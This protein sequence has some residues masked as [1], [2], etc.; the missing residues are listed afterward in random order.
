MPMKPQKTSYTSN[1][2][3]VPADFL[4]R[5]PPP[6]APPVTLRKID[7]SATPLPENGPRYA[8][9]ID[10]VLTADEC[11][12][13]VRMAEDSAKDRGDAGD[14]PW[15]PAMVNIGPGW[16]VL[17]PHYRNSDRIIWDQ[18][19][20]VD[21]LWARCRLAPGL[22]D[23][24]K[25]V[26]AAGKTRKGEE[27][28]WVFNRF[29]KRMRL[30][31]YQKGQF[32]RPHCDGPY[33]EEGA[34]GTVF[35]TWHTVHLY[36][37]D[38]A[39]EVGPEKSGLAGGATTFLSSDEK[40]RVDVDPRAGRVLIFQHAGLYHCGDDVVEGTKLTMRTDILYELVKTK[41]EEGRQSR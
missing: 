13:L 34:D 33:G 23:Q 29:N 7:W 31:R 3:A 20:V 39:A 30:L 12:R 41:T 36:L 40:R 35:R 6:G 37:N 2:V 28:R 25:E 15:Q 26:A 5:P 10:N 22:E 27:T 19:E 32:F 18:Q 17:E 16:E 38:S 8:A 9:V 21:R 24:L 11:A 1:D 14:E 4:S